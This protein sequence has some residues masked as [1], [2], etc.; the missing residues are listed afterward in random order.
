MTELTLERDM[1]L[2]LKAQAHPLHPVVLLG[3]SG[4]TPA[5]LAEVDRA[6]TAHSLIKVRV[7]LDDRAERETIFAAIADKLGAARVQAIGKLVVLFRPPPP[8]VEPEKPKAPPPARKRSGP[9]QSRPKKA[10]R[11]GRQT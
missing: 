5:V 6:L 7:P 4:L 3:A 1:R 9:E 11:G 8:D 10:R 2:A